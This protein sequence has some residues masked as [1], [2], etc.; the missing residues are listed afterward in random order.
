MVV[1]ENTQTKMAVRAIKGG[2]DVLI[3]IKLIEYIFMIKINVNR[4]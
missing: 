2:I 4:I 3:L 1:V